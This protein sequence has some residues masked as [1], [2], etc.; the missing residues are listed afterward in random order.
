MSIPG[1]ILLPLAHSVSVAK[2]V[3]VKEGKGKIVFEGPDA[4]TYILHF[5]DVLT[6]CDSEETQIHGKG[7]FHNRL[8]ALLMSRLLEVNIP[9]HFL[10]LV[11][12]REQLVRSMD[13]LPFRVRV[14]DV[15]IDEYAHNL[16]RISGERLLEPLM[17]L[18][19][20]SGRVIAPQH[21]QILGLSDHE[22]MERLFALIQRVHD[23]LVGF[24]SAFGLIFLRGDFQVGRSYEDFA[25]ET[26]L[27]LINELSL[28]NLC[29]LDRDSCQRLDPLLDMSIYQGLA[30]RF[31]MI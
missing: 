22:E 5:K 13:P 8:S 11:N 4:G 24:F 30:K 25:G 21:A 31:H 14:H 26:N 12:M 18:C 28:D 7:S 3:T 15:L 10:K 2:K 20:P 23:F 17:E 9:N 19:L 16:E 6:S 27:A 1:S 29:L